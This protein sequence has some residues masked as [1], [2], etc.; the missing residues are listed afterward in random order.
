MEQVLFT[1]TLDSFP[2]FYLR[3]RMMTRTATMTTA[4]APMIPIGTQSKGGGGVVVVVV[5]VV[6]ITDG[7][8]YSS[9]R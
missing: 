6:G 4:D 9:I 1:G 2:E 8:M 3:F 5:V 7:S